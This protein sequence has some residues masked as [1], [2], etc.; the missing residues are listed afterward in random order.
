MP[1]KTTKL[2]WLPVVDGDLCNGCQA[3][4]DACEPR[5]LEIIGIIAILTRPD[6]CGS[7]E[8]CIAP[9]PIGAIS[10]QWVPLVG[11]IN[12]GKWQMTSKS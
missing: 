4:A 8:H 3:C 1:M 9:C 2:K 11:D 6:I 10:M 12:I 7:E 5:C